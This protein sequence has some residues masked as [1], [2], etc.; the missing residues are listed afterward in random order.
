M[1]A[2]TESRKGKRYQ[3]RDDL[4]QKLTKCYGGTSLRHSV[5]TC[6]RPSMGSKKS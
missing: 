1:V 6:I 3:N 2:R 4:T 5:N